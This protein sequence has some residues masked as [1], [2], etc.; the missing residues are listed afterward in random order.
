MNTKLQDLAVLSADEKR[1]LLEQMLEQKAE[2]IPLSFAQQRLWFLDQLRPNSSLY[3]VPTAVRIK[4]FLNIQAL[5]DS[6]ETLVKRHEILRTVYDTSGESPIQII[7]DRFSVALPVFDLNETACPDLEVELSRRL[8]EE[9]AKP[10][11]LAKDLML[12][13]GLFRL[14]IKEHVLF[15]N[16]HHIA[17]DE[18]SLKIFFRELLICYTAFCE[19][20][21]PALKPLAI[22][23]ADFASWQ[24]ESLQ[25]KLLAEQLSFWKEHLG[26][27]VHP[28][29]LPMDRSR[30]LHASYVGAHCQKTFSRGLLQSLKVICRKEG[31]TL[32]MLLLAAFNTVLHRYTSQE[33]IV[34][35]TPVAGRNRVETED[36]IGFFVNTLP[37]RTSFAGDPTFQQL[38]AQQRSTCL[39]AFSRQDLPFERLVE[40]LQPDRNAT[41]NPLF[42][43]MFSLQSGLRDKW[44]LPG[45]TFEP[46]ELE[47]GTAKFDLT[48]AMQENADSLS[49]TAEFSTEIFDA[50]TIER[51]LGHIEVVLEAVVADPQQ[52]VSR[53]PLL[54]ANERQRIVL[55]W[56]RTSTEYPRNAAVHELFEKAAAKFP[57]SIAVS[58]GANQLT[59]R[60]LNQRA[61]Q[62]ANFLRKHG[63][64]TD[65]PIGISVERSVEMIV[66]WLGILKAG[67]AYVPL[68]P[69]YPKERLAFMVE[70]TRMPVLLTQKSLLQNL[71]S[72]NTKV[73]SLDLDWKSIANESATAPVTGTGPENL[74]YVIYTSGSTGRP[75]GVAVTHRGIVRLVFN[76]NYVQFDRND[77]LAQ[78]SNS[79]FDAATFEVWG[80]L[81][82]GGELVGVNK[83]VFLSPKDFAHFLREQKITGMF[84]TVAL[85]NQI[86]AEVPDAF[87]GIKNV[88]FGGDAADAKSV[89]TVLESGAPQHLING[90]GPTESTTF[91]SCYEVKEVAPEARSIPIGRPISNTTY[92]VLDKNLQPLPVGIPGELYIGG[93]GLARGY[94]NRPELTASRFVANPFG[95]N[96]HLYKTG[97]LVR[98]LPDGN[99]DFLGRID[100][101]VKIRGFRIEPEEIEAV[102][103]QQE[104]IRDAAV[105]VRE[106]SPNEKRLVAYAVPKAGS[107]IKPDDLRN[108][109]RQ[110]LPEYMIP[111]AF[112]LM[113]S[114]PLT[115]NGKIN[116]RI[117]PKPEAN[118]ASAEA[119]EGPRSFLEN[120]LRRIWQDVLGCA[121]VGVH[122]NFFELGGHSLLAV[123]LFSQ[124]EKTLGQKLPLQILFQAPTIESLARLMRDKGWSPAGSSLVEI[125]GEGS[126]SPIFWLH[127]LGG[128]GGG[129]LF[130]Y[131][132]LAHL[133][134]DD[135][136][137][138]GFVAPDEP[139]SD[140]ESMAA[141]YIK[142]MR[143]IQPKGPYLLGGYCFGGVIAYEMARQLVQSGEKLAL[144]A[145]IESVPPHVDCQSRWTVEMFLHF[146]RTLPSWLAHQKVNELWRRI[147]GKVKRIGAK[148]LTKSKTSS[149]GQNPA[150]AGLND[151]IDM[152]HYPTNFRRFAEI[153]W[154]ALLHYFPKP[155]PGQVTLFRTKQPRLLT[156]DPEGSWRK[157][158][159]G[160]VD[161]RLVP[162]SHETILHE[163][164]VHHLAKE[165]NACLAKIHATR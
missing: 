121:S 66:G 15:L 164:D 57:N 133:L 45:L 124:I 130:T 11:D 50:S 75:K 109:L 94:F 19:K 39:N 5:Q 65:V 81:L 60:E 95:P 100:T 47:N 114:F 104:S 87:R 20:T 120:Q 78:I 55:D 132:E 101:Q 29:E 116:R 43:L 147:E 54:S 145:L 96:S 31:V 70:D 154:N 42:N 69:E 18:W 40:E 4:G 123:R 157:L 24:R 27:D 135:Q 36:L 140:I 99:I 156:L 56:N 6:L 122:D 46:I 134:G 73:F 10:F 84:L 112:V 92:Y 161:L 33:D 113:E 61:N 48:L 22:Q 93:D 17:F 143:G 148:V 115:P 74:A 151:V 90:Y 9:A 64:G 150:T 162:G 128:G 106:D 153:H 41:Q 144:L 141:H 13:A 1:A 138:Y 26:P 117:L 58:Y 89:R 21:T 23:Y 163:P 146:C 8:R 34:V 125:K 52:K 80:S 71:P 127:T 103:K 37:L 82:H 53:L 38:L 51:M 119:V 107:S 63:A 152:T 77:R 30:P 68:D 131:H 110:T 105:L 158:S 98:W 67:A 149:E 7:K 126:R 155:F 118:L 108:A 83:Q 72:K 12:R 3:N 91:S 59:Y 49:A 62:L 28:L 32:Y 76:T 136:P 160:G 85:F 159:Q 139:H 14:T 35:G 79:S 86:V 2:Q 129:G 44:D 137:S 102:L 25:S 165:L 97:D 88:L 111:S 16:V 142:E